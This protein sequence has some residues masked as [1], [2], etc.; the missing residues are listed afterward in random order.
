MILL[1]LKIASDYFYSFA[2]VFTY[3]Q[4]QAYYFSLIHAFTTCI[5][6]IS[7][8]ALFIFPLISVVTSQLNT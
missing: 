2:H 5:A 4:F 8:C 3:H 7:K 1:L 6:L